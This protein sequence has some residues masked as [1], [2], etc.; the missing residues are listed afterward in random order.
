MDN[1][2]V[3]HEGESVTTNAT[4]LKLFLDLLKEHHV[5]AYICGHTHK[6][7]VAKVKGIWQ[8]DSGHSRGAGDKMTPSTFLRFRISGLRAWVDVYRADA[9]GEHYEIKK[10]VELD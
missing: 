9:N 4:R 6:T 1:G 2:K 3:G 5:R 10:T 8:A 7:S